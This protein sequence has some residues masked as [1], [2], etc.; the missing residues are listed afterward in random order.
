MTIAIKNIIKG[1]LYPV[2]LYAR[3]I[4]G[5]VV[6]LFLAR[7]L[8]VYDYGLFSSYKA[9]AAFWLMFANLGFNEYI[10]VSSNKVVKDVQLKIG[11]FLI[12][13]VILMCCVGFLSMFS[14]LEIKYL[15][16]LVLIRQ[17]LD[18]TFFAIA[19]P[20]FQAANKFNI[21]SCVNLFYSAM[22][23]IITAVCYIL[24]L[25]L[26]KFLLLSIALGLFNF[27]QVSFYA[28]INYILSL[29]YLKRLLSRLDKSIWAYTGVTLCCYLYSQIP[30]LYSSMF[31]PKEEA[32]LYFAAFTIA[33]IISLLLAAQGQKMVPEMMNTSVKRIK[34]V[35]NF[36]LKL[37]MSINLAVFLFFVFFG[38]WLLKLIYSNPYYV[39]AYPILLV[40]TLGNISIAL[41]AIY[42]TYITASGNQKQKIRMQV[43]AI[44]ITIITLALFHKFG[45]YAAA[46]AY[47]LAATH[48]GIRY[49]FKAKKLLKQAREYELQETKKYSKNITHRL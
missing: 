47:I 14:T 16:I 31:V 13:A 9:I 19:L 36:N 34:E 2:S 1:S 32:A 46:L 39:N 25:S 11:L 4:A 49:V 23:I 10:L 12:N 7:Y 29:K 44:F 37:L 35:I 33:T 8:S 30:S 3:Q 15:F 38:K 43:E 28:K 26:V 17:F 40:L 5:T 20:Y 45:I 42:G 18:G 48:I 41:A 21:I 22:V 6:L 24:K 27:V